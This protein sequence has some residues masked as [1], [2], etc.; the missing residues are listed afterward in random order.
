MAGTI[1][2]KPIIF[3]IVVTLVVLI[4]TA[5]MMLLPMLSS[6][7]HPKLSTLKPYTALQL[8]G[9][10]VYQENGCFYC[11]TQTVRP[12]K[13]E[14][15][16]YGEYSKAGEFA[17][18]QPF[19]W[20][21]KRTGPDLAREGAKYP[22]KWHYDHFNDPRKL[23]TDSNMPSY[24]WLSD[25]RLDPKGVKARM[26][27]LGFPYSEE[28]IEALSNK[29]KLDALVAYVQ[30][31]GTAVPKK[32][33]V[34]MI[35]LGE[36]NPLSGDPNA[37]AAG[38]KIY[39]TN[40]A[41]CHGMDAKGGIGPDLTGKEWMYVQGP[42]GDDTL[43]LIIA[44][45]TKKDQEFEGRKAKGGMPSWSEFIGKKDIWSLVSYIRSLEK[46]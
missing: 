2:K 13:A 29:T 43:F 7:M 35:A 10:D 18:D 34:V 28:E 26:Q 24:G 5:V 9:R 38:K 32:S 17:Y 4:G 3:A 6:S 1:Y 16:R 30:S 31:L 40:C 22:D 44:G 11:H 39:E 45:G 37:I 42:I 41:A 33:N 15:M 36:K 12:L 23:F 14:V 27:T 8:A 21:S 25:Y 20:G 19:L 46:K